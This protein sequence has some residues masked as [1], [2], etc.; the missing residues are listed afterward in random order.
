M[1]VPRV[2]RGGVEWVCP[3]GGW[4][5]ALGAYEEATWP[6]PLDSGY[7]A[8]ALSARLR[9]RGVTGVRRIGGVERDGRWVAQVGVWPMDPSIID[10]VTR[11]AAPVPVVIEPC[12]DVFIR[13][14]D[15]PSAKLRPVR[16]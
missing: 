12:Q 15:T 8:A 7:L 16:P 6:P 14:A 9:R 10:A 1:L 2:E 13:V 3:D 11:A 4:R 5:C